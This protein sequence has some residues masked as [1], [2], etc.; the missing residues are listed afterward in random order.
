[1]HFAS[2]FKTSFETSDEQTS[3]KMLLNISKHY[4]WIDALQ[5]MRQRSFC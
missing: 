5:A 1:M 4:D 2:C 3:H